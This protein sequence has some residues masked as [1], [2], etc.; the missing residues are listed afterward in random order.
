MSAG[1]HWWRP[2]PKRSTVTPPVSCAYCGLIP[3]KNEASAK[4]VKQ[5][6]KAAHLYEDKRK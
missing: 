2:N 3:L 5:P 1:H 6:C 4:A